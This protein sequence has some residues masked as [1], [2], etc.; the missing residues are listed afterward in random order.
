MK[1]I[2]SFEVTSY[3][4]RSKILELNK[5]IS[6]LEQKIK[7]IENNN[8]CLEKS[9]EFYKNELN[10][11]LNS[12][13]WKITKP[14]RFIRKNAKTNSENLDKKDVT[15][16]NSILKSYRDFPAY[17]SEYQKDIDFSKIKTDIK[18]LAFYLPQFHTFKENDEWWGKG[19]TEWTN[20]KKAKP[21][22][23]GHYQ[24][25]IP[26]SDFGY[27]KLDN[28]NTIKKQVSLAKKHNIYGFIFYYYWFSGKRL[29]E[30]PIDL[31]LNDKSIDFPFCLCWANENWTR[32]WDG[33]ENDILIKQNYSKGDYKKFINDIKKYIIDERYIRIDGKPVIL[34]YNPKEIPNFGEL[35][36]EWRK[37]ALEESIGEI[38]ILAKCDFSTSGEE[39]ADY[40]DACFDFPPHGV[41]HP[42]TK[43]TG[44]SSEKIF[45]Y[46]KIVNDIDHLYKEHFP[47]KPFYYSVTMGWDN[48]SRRKEGYTIYYN[49]NLVSF[50]KW[51]RM[52][53]EETR[54][55]NNPD[56]RYIFVNAWNEWAEGTYLE[57]D[58]KYGY[59][60]INTLSKAICD[61]PLND[62]NEKK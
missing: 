16:F 15:S 14:L 2:N 59:A 61:L 26:H 44:L 43:L 28:I 8:I 54:R 38:Y 17:T 39:Y 3:D 46:E 12:T 50:Y 31:F 48:S 24:P 47:L 42:E 19:F 52:I 6:L 4:Y 51:L 40:V 29:M 35:V 34:V 58:E 62:N 45:N 21:L 18:T 30:K 56:H 55:R 37:Y 1:D 57:P 41:G 49:Y 23:T 9:R 32:T 25:R 10:N 27:Y 7:K 22:F 36:N 33:L 60:N 11:V 5:K 53:I 20:T 13:S